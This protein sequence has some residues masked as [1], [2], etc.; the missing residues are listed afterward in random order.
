MAAGLNPVAIST[1]SQ[2][3][4]LQSPM[5]RKAVSFMILSLDCRIRASVH[6]VQPTLP[7]RHWEFP[8]R[9]FLIY[10]FGVYGSSSFGPWPGTCSR[11][12]GSQRGT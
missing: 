7:L 9:A 5:R 6:D 3:V 8:L 1:T 10:S 2:R 4:A 12:T 11:C